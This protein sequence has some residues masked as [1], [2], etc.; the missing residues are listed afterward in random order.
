RHDYGKRSSCGLGTWPPS[1]GLW[2]I[3]MCRLQ[4]IISI[5]NSM[6]SAPRWITA[7]QATCSGGCGHDQAF[8]MRYYFHYQISQYSTTVIAE[9]TTNCKRQSKTPRKV[10]VWPFQ[11][12][13]SFSS[14][15]GSVFLVKDDTT[16]IAITEAVLPQSPRYV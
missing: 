15:A 14:L 5:R 13:V 11:L 3:E 1:R 2:D 7:R 12:T 8:G 10:S 9:R 4:C 16:N 6:S